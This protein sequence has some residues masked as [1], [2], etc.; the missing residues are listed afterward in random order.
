M[1]IAQGLRDLKQGH[2]QNKGAG[3]QVQPARFRNRRR[4]IRRQLFETVL[5]GRYIS[6]IASSN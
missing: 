1:L 4:E 5:P 6:A 2:R 3:A